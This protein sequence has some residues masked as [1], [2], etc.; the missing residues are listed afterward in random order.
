MMYSQPPLGGKSA[1]SRKGGGQ[2]LMSN[3]MFW[4]VKAANFCTVN[5]HA[6]AVG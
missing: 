4:L 1:W 6:K 5:E 2:L 3:D